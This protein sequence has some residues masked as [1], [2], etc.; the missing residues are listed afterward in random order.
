MGVA[1]EAKKGLTNQ[2]RMKGLAEV[3]KRD[4]NDGQ[5]DGSWNT[6]KHRGKVDYWLSIGCLLGG[7]RGPMT[8]WGMENLQDLPCLSPS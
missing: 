5:M 1:S 8:L 7:L 3:N 6:I 2:K 4:G